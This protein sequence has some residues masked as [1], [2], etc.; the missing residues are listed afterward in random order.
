MVCITRI[1]GFGVA[2][3]PNDTPNGIEYNL[4]YIGRWILGVR[5]NCGT[6]SAPFSPEGIIH[7]SHTFS[8]VSSITYEN[9]SAIDPN[10]PHDCINGGCLPATVYNTPGI[11]AT[12]ASC[13]SGCAKNSNCKGECVSVE[14]LAA[15]QQAANNLRGRLCG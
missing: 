5:P 14:E 11:F 7:P 15:L 6:N 4:T 10:K 13:E 3:C 9:C 12:F 2:G 8:S 1:I